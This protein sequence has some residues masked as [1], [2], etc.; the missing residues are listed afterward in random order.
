MGRTTPRGYF[1]H[2]ILVG[3]YLGKEPYKRSNGRW[4]KDIKMGFRE[5]MCVK[6]IHVA[7]DRVHWRSFVIKVTNFYVPQKQGIS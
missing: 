5:V 4:E 6:W 3:K 7:Q 1:Y 2:Y